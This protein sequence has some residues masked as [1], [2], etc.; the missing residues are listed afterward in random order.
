MTDF[1][2][3]ANIV[4]SILI[5]GK[6]AY[7]P[8]LSFH[9]FLLPDFALIEIDKYQ[10][11]IKQKSKG[12]EDQLLNWTYFVFSELIILPAF[13]LQ[14][15][16]LDKSAQLL[17]EID[18]KDISYVALAMQLDLPLL[19]RDRTLYEGLRKQGFRKVMIFDAYL[20]SL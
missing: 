8:I 1:V 18:I 17:S 11:A 9:H 3:D 14:Q 19:T 16:A 13:I 12:T 15:Q 20:R 4:M 5:S 7:R 6:S 10:E 2:I